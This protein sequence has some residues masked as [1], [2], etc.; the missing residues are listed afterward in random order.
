MTHGPTRFELR[1][2][3]DAGLEENAAN[4]ALGTREGVRLLSNEIT[5]K[6]ERTGIL[7]EFF[8]TII[9]PNRETDRTMAKRKEVTGRHDHI[10]LSQGRLVRIPD[11][12]SRILCQSGVGRDWIT[13]V[14]E[15]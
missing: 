13:V 5:G 12:H 9:T 7:F 8:V 10:N 4:L 3:R 14:A 6:S 2:N 11:G 15:R 1:Q